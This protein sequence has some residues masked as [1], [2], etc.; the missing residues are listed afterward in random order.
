MKEY[1]PEKSLEIHIA[2]Y[3]AMSQKGS[4]GFIEETVFHNLIDHYCI[5]EY[6]RC[7][8]NY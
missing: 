6:P 3:E 2:E 7:I 5:K 1:R 4:V 8:P